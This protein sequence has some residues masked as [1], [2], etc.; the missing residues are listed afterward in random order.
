MKQTSKNGKGRSPL[1][2]PT[3]FIWKTIYSCRLK[4]IIHNEGYARL[5]SDCSSLDAIA[6]RLIFVITQIV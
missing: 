5:N 3:H 1:Q 4:R 2:T 6:S